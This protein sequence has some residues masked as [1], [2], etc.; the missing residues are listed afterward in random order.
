MCFNHIKSINNEPLER[1][2][3]F[4]IIHGNHAHIHKK[5]NVNDQNS[6]FKRLIELV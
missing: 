6:T 5:Y 4:V 2:M 3:L 1:L